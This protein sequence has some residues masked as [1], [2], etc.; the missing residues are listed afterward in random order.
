M[1]TK[2]YHK[3]S[4][5]AHGWVHDTI[6][7]DELEGHCGRY[8]FD[9]INFY[10]GSVVVA[11]RLVWKGKDQENSRIIYLLGEM[12]VSAWGNNGVDIHIIA[13]AIPNRLWVDG[14]EWVV[15]KVYVNSGFYPF[16][17]RDNNP[18]ELIQELAINRKARDI[19]ET[20]D[21]S[22]NARENRAYYISSV[23][24]DWA[25]LEK[26]VDKYKSL[27][28]HISMPE[29]TWKLPEPYTP[30][31][32]KRRKDGYLVREVTR[33]KLRADWDAKVQA[34]LDEWWEREGKDKRE[35]IFTIDD[36]GYGTPRYSR[37]ELPSEVRK[38]LQELKTNWVNSLTPGVYSKDE[39]NKIEWRLRQGTLEKIGAIYEWKLDRLFRIP[40]YHSRNTSTAYNN[41]FNN[42]LSHIHINPDGSIVTSQG[43]RHPKDSAKVL[44]YVGLRVLDGKSASDGGN[45]GV[46]SYS[47]RLETREGGRALV[48]GCHWFTEEHFRAVAEEWREKFMSEEEKEAN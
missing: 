2:R 44:R 27:G 17:W 23:T 33:T 3:V 12:D 21:R 15:E 38:Y 1:S 30:G 36:K 47:F 45:V 16:H 20:V 5:L 14:V 4:E 22:Y 25:A 43:I 35:E 28:M 13:R 26:F 11:K 19:K 31:G 6:G 48:I 32:A 41:I 29:K 7:A 42:Y 34:E 9:N 46:G 40:W 18:Q 37:N 24:S 8:K 39:E 10:Q